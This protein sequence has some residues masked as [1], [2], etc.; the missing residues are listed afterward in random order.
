MTQLELQRNVKVFRNHGMALEEFSRKTALVVVA[1]AG[2][3]AA[4]SGVMAAVCA[5]SAP[6]LPEANFSGVS[7]LLQD[8]A[9]AKVGAHLRLDASCVDGAIIWGNSWGVHFLPDL[10]HATVTLPETLARLRERK[11]PARKVV[12]DDVWLKKDL[13][14][15]ETL[16]FIS[17]ASRRS[18]NEV[19]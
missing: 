5:R 18:Y 10:Y 6:S 9:E 11:Q 19:S 16:R 1:G 3:A 13:H 8:W 15:Y 4:Y 14:Q 7:R 12:A 17:V 2:P